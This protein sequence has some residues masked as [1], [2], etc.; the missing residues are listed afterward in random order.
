VYRN[1]HQQD[2]DLIKALLKRESVSLMSI[3]ELK[4]ATN[5]FSE[6]TAIGKGGF[7]KA[8]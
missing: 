2:A 6:N 5:N 3:Q 8:Q 7:G 1:L 4:K